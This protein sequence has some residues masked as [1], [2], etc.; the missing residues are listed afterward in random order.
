MAWGT[1]VEKE[2]RR[3]IMVAVAA[4]AY[5]TMDRPIMSDAAFDRLAGNIDLKISTGNVK[6]DTWFKN[7]FKS[8]TGMWV[9]K[10]PDRKGLR[11]IAEFIL[12]G[13]GDE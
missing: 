4:Y 5:E 2:R 10:H 9:H 12:E 6:L 8:H 13:K 7:N 3:R 11:R 1:R